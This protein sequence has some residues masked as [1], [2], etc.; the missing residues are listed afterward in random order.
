[1][2][3]N[4]LTLQCS[5]RLQ[6]TQPSTA[7][8]NTSYVNAVCFVKLRP[9]EERCLDPLPCSLVRWK[10]G[11][12]RRQITV[13]DHN[14]ECII[15]S[16]SLQIQPHFH[17]HLDIVIIHSTPH[18]CQSC[19]NDDLPWREKIMKLQLDPVSQSFAPYASWKITFK[20]NSQSP[21]F[22]ALGAAGDV[23]NNQQIGVK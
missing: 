20:M 5:T 16:T 12:M 7:T 18:P 11:N 17:Q 6:E 19:S 8:S 2:N 3:S 22:S 21:M 9:A 14:P 13:S 1:M 15:H 10:P 23:K 4:P